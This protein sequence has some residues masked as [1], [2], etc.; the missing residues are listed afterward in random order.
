MTAAVPPDTVHEERASRPREAPLTRA[1]LE[2]HF[3]AAAFVVLLLVGA[4]ATLRAYL[5]LERAI[6]TWLEFQW[7]PIAQAAFSILVAA[8]CVWLIRSWVI[9]RSRD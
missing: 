3:R 7:V 6:V 1:R 5:A 9:G 2:G 8:A 4:I